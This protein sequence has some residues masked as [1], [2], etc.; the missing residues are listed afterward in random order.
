MNAKT[1]P[2]PQPIDKVK[3]LDLMDKTFSLGELKTLCFQIGVDFDN[4]DGTNKHDKIR[5]LIKYCARRNILQRLLS[6]CQK[7]REKVDWFGITTGVQA[8]SA[9]V[10]QKLEPAITNDT[11]EN[12]PPLKPVAVHKEQSKSIKQ[13]SEPLPRQ[14]KTI[15]K[16]PE[17]PSNVSRNIDDQ[18]FDIFGDLFMGAFFTSGWML[19]GGLTAAFYW[20]SAWITLI[21]VAIGAGVGLL[22]VAM[23]WGQSPIIDALEPFVDITVLGLSVGCTISLFG[24]VIWGI[25]VAELPELTWV[26]LWEAVKVTF[27][28]ALGFI[29]GGTVIGA[30]AFPVGM[31]LILGFLNLIR[32]RILSQPPK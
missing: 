26:A 8:K 12:P 25:V 31:I 32:N 21:C 14:S 18:V 9:K 3:L 27:R 23:V 24:G 5:E 28:T 17:R 22:Q 10:P 13:P 7:E 2:A 30:A 16:Q 19:L 6:Q 11:A 15:S 1:N 20:D 4:I 29:V